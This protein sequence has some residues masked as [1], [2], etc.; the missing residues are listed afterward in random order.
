MKA[1]SALLRRVMNLAALGC[2][3]LAAW[4]QT[5]SLTVM[6]NP[7]TPG[8]SVSVSGSGFPASANITVS[9]AGNVQSVMADSLG[10]FMTGPFSIPSSAG[11]TMLT[12]TANGGGSSASASVMVQRLPTG[13]QPGAQTVRPGG[14]AHFMGSGFAPNEMVE[15]TES[16]ALAQSAM[17]DSMG[18]FSVAVTI[19]A[20]AAGQSRIYSF[21]GQQSGT[22]AGAT[23][24]VAGASASLSVSRAS[25]APGGS[26]SVT[27]SGFGPN[28]QVL[29]TLN[30]NSAGSARSSETGGVSLA[31]AV[32]AGASG[33][34]IISARGTTSG[35]S[36]M[37]GFT[38][39]AP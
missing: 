1:Q 24:N 25:V 17:A 32:P 39:M 14:S 13:V 4:A 16:G 22:M 10:S 29:F 27:G 38:V 8:Q 20:S 23:V 31:I 21:K 36:A 11:N 37:A 9:V 30:G 15:I 12:V 26:V 6:P 2:L 3:A 7:A 35:I 28:E 34:Q 19:P 18:S 33:A 5:G